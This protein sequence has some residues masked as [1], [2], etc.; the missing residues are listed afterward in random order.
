MHFI[1]VKGYAYWPNLNT[2]RLLCSKALEGWLS[3]EN[4]ALRNVYKPLQ[5]IVRFCK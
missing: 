4:G 2:G 5:L 1:R 3:N